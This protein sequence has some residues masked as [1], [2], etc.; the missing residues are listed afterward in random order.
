MG[1]DGPG[2]DES[3]RLHPADPLHVARLEAL[4]AEDVEENRFDFELSS[5]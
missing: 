2:Y 3:W 4:V 5:E 1:F